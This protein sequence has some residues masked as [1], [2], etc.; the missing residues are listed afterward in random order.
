MSSK[1]LKKNKANKLIYTIINITENTKEKECISADKKNEKKYRETIEKLGITT[2]EWENT[3]V[4]LNLEIPTPPNP[5]NYENL[6]EYRRTHVLRPA[7]VQS[8]ATIY[9]H[10]RGYKLGIDYQAYQAIEIVNKLQEYEME[11]SLPQIQQP[12]INQREIDL[13]V[14]NLS[15][16]TEKRRAN[17]E[18]KQ[19]NNSIQKKDSR[20]GASFS[21]GSFKR[22]Q[23]KNTESVAEIAQKINQNCGS[24]KP[25]TRF[26]MQREGSFQSKN[27]MKD[28]LFN[29]N[30]S[31]PLEIKGRKFGSRPFSY[32]SYSHTPASSNIFNPIQATAPP[33]PPHYQSQ[34]IPSANYNPNYHQNTNANSNSN[35]SVDS[36]FD[37]EEM[38]QFEKKYNPQKDKNTNDEQYQNNQKKYNGIYPPLHGVNG[39]NGVN[40]VSGVN[41]ESEGD[42]FCSI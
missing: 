1:V 19:K 8:E 27:E 21:Y 3:G 26:N 33:M 5:S 30:T 14:L 13:D 38:K 35:S 39:V 24:G 17:L 22:K 25:K 32:H 11:N 29:N 37:S 10:E 16:D 31:R 12:Q 15:R 23:N 18:Y 40:S 34:F 41:S 7:I 42:D 2:K 20:R 4:M 36:L 9:L 28:T 6:L